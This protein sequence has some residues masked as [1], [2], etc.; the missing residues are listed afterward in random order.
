MRRTPQGR[1]GEI[2]WL[3]WWTTIPE[4]P[5]FNMVWCSSTAHHYGL[6]RPTMTTRTS[7]HHCAFSFGRLYL[8]HQCPEMMMFHCG[9]TKPQEHFFQRRIW[10]S[11]S[12]PARNCILMRNDSVQRISR[13]YTDGVDTAT[14][15]CWGT[16][17]CHTDRIQTSS[18][19][20]SV[21]PH[22]L[23]RGLNWDNLKILIWIAR[24]SSRLDIVWTGTPQTTRLQ[25]KLA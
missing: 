18:F 20:I 14:E 10:I 3:K 19:L 5:G 22:R 1:W 24:F 12:M 17:F 6:P 4:S 8:H 2:R 16:Q 25:S 21:K 11:R 15:D 9:L 13:A 7:R 23:R